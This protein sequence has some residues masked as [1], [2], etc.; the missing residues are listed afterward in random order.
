MGIF[1]DITYNF[2]ESPTTTVR[3]YTENKE[4]STAANLTTA[5]STRIGLDGVFDGS[6]TQM[7][8]SNISYLSNVAGLTIFMA[9][10]LD[11][12]TGTDYIFNINGIIDCTWDGTTLTSNL[13]TTSATYSATND[14]TALSTGTWYDVILRFNDATKGWRMVVDG[15]NQAQT[16]TTGSTPVLSPNLEIGW[17][18]STDYGKFSLN[19]FKLYGETITTTIATELVNSQNGVVLTGTEIGLTEGDIIGSSLSGSAV[20]G[21]VGFADGL[22]TIRMYPISDLMKIS[23]TFQRVAH[24]WD[25][26]RQ[27]ALK[28]DDDEICFYDGMS[29]SSEVLTEAKKTYCVGRYGII[30]NGATKTA[31]YTLTDIDNIIYASGTIT[32]KF[33]STP[34]DNKR[35]E[36]VNVGTGTV[37]LDGNGKNINGLSTQPLASK[38][39]AAKTIYSGTEHIFD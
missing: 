36:I 37:T 13:T 39:D 38:Y 15:V 1:A 9:I 8:T 18:G 19:E 2:N 33:P 21:I 5:T 17:D 34:R 32:I 25:T 31:D 6:S 26:D 27:Y 7:T 11:V 4:D 3:D 29:L 20:Y 23:G 35:Y 24:L 16:V 12:S 22:G 28:I 30:E 14:V 10:K